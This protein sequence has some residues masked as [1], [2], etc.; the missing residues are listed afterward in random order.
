MSTIPTQS[1][2]IPKSKLYRNLTKSKS[3]SMNY[4]LKILPNG[5]KALLI[6]DPDAHKSSAAIAVNIGYLSDP[7]SSPGLAHFCEHMLFLGTEKYPKEDEYHSFVAKN[8]GNSNAYTS[9]DVTCYYFDVSNEAFDQALDRFAQFFI[10]P[11]FNKESVDKEI[12]AIDSENK[13]NNVM[14]ALNYKLDKLSNK[15]T[16]IDKKNK[17][18][19]VEY[20]N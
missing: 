14:F 12:R 20:Y 9:S 2:P 11:L 7:V 16:D 19:N 13:K 4:L 10:K 3:D 8:G 18:F 6:S 1:E 5:L 15:L 17:K